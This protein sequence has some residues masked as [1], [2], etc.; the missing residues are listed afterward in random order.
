MGPR[1]GRFSGGEASE[2]GSGFDSWIH[3][4][5]RVDGVVR[6]ERVRLD[7]GAPFNWKGLT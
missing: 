7:A 3:T 6:G 1:V 5:H 4:Q 2:G